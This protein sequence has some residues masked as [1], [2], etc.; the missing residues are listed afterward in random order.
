MSRVQ[1]EITLGI[2]LVLATG[3]LLIYHGLGE[4]ERMAEF[5]LIQQ[6][7]AIEVGAE[8]F[9]NNCRP[10]H[11]AQGEGT[12]LLCPPLNDKYFFT[13]RVK[14]VGWPGSLEDYIIAT[15]SSGRLLSTRPELYPGNSRPVMA[16][17]SEEFGGPLRA[18][19][20]RSLAAFIMNWESTAP[21]RQTAPALEGPPVGTDIAQELPEG[22]PVKG[23]SLAA[24]QGC[25]GCHVSTNTGPAWLATADQPGIGARAETRFSDAAYTGRATSAQQYL[26]ESV[27]NPAA[28]I[29]PGFETVNMPPNYGQLLTA[30]D[31]ADLIAY[32]LTLK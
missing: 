30:Q 4:E 29:V 25:A 12:P 31:A 32:M 1:I 2:L 11:G 17:W 26:L 27:V 16:A 13:E 24:T 23:E 21:D 18:D 7:Q 10:C 5:E 3:T 28:Y 19:Q 22:D 15:V 14:E 9:E 20:I 6:G 8:L